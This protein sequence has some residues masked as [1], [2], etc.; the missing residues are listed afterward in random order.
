MNMFERG[1]GKFPSLQ[2]ATL[3]AGLQG[4]VKYLK[5]SL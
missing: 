4:E 5:E 2:L 1:N 3:T